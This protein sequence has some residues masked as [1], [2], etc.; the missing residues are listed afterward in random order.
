MLPDVASSQGRFP[1]TRMLFS[2]SASQQ[3][4]SADLAPCTNKRASRKA[5]GGKRKRTFRGGAEKGAALSVYGNF[6]TRFSCKATNSEDESVLYS[7]LVIP[8]YS[9]PVFIQY[10]FI[11]LILYR[12]KLRLVHIF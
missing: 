7:F 3:A 10:T 1:S 5:K 9:G 2:V 8:E 11:C 4:R 6:P 12:V